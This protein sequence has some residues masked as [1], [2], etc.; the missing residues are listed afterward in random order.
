MWWQDLKHFL[1]VNASGIGHLEAASHKVFNSNDGGRVR[2]ARD[3]FDF[4]VEHLSMYH[5]HFNVNS[6]KTGIPFERLISQLVE[7]I[8]KTKA[9]PLEK[10]AAPASTIVVC[11]FNVKTVLEGGPHYSKGEKENQLRIHSLAA[12][13]ASLWQV[14]MGRVVVVGAQP[15]DGEAAKVAFDLVSGKTK[16]SMELSFVISNNITTGLDNN[17]LMPK[18]AIAGLQM[19]LIGKLNTSQTQAWVGDT[20]T[21]WKYVYFTE[22]DLVLS[23]RPG[24]I[25]ALTSEL[26]KG[27][28]LAGHRLQ[29]IPHALDFPGFEDR[30]N[31]LVPAV[32][33]FSAAS[34]PD[35]DTAEYACCDAGNGRPGRDIP[36][37]ECGTFW[38]Q[39]GFNMRNK[40][41]SNL[42]GVLDAHRRKVPYSWMRLSTGTG[43]VMMA[44]TE[45]ARQCTLLHHGSCSPKNKVLPAPAVHDNVTVRALEIAAANIA[46]EKKENIPNRVTH[47]MKS[48]EFEHQDPYSGMWWQNVKGFMKFPASEL[49]NLEAASF[50]AIRELE[51]VLMTRDWLDFAVEHLSMYQRHF[52]VDQAKNEVAY[53]KLRKQ[54]QWSMERT[55]KFSI[56]DNMAPRRTIAI[57]PFT[58]SMAGSRKEPGE[59]SRE[60]QIDALAATLASLWQFGIGRAVVVGKTQAD[61]EFANIAF[62]RLQRIQPTVLQSMDLAFV[63]GPPIKEEL[64]PKQALLGLQRVLQG[65]P[66]MTATDI[67]NWLGVNHVSIATRWLYV[68]FSE[69]DLVLN[70]RASAIPRLTTE[71]DEGNLIAAHRLQ[72]VPHALDFPG[73]SDQFHK[74]VPALGNFTHIYDMDAAKSSC[75]DAGNGRPGMEII[76]KD[77][78]GWWW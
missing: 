40:N 59:N 65:H 78:H 15:V 49:G 68:Y 77:C 46:L 67:E 62:T 38:Y 28:V 41:Y 76:Q 29:P 35:V 3:W 63:A 57:L 55:Q 22:P 37:P 16:S 60:L 44:T 20:A 56:D 50:G 32:G 53:K 33:N 47:L 61:E 51:R 39:C 2:M 72:P 6:E 74:T 7:Y 45:H 54:M 8:Q 64:V 69:P 42:E 10:D 19:A 73:Y 66:N 43:S 36:Q 75:C 34:I 70:S 27:R 58:V 25:H 18:Q 12:T 5:R 48:P 23:S 31:N 14:G 30:R 21:R 17:A 4:A 24:S 52:E 1:E 11:A 26:E 13:L 71:L 9:Y